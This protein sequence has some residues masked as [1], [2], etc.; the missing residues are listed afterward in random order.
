MPKK[1]QTETQ[2]SRLLGNTP[3]QI[4]LELIATESHESVNTPPEHLHS[5]YKTFDDVKDRYFD[6]MSP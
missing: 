1:I 6:G 4:D 3:L 5:F 2:L